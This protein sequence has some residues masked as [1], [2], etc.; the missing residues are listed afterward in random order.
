M[1]LL[2]LFAL[3]G[4]F[5]PFELSSRLFFGSILFVAFIV[6][7]AHLSFQP[8]LKLAP[9]IIFRLDDRFRKDLL[10]FV[11]FAAIGIVIFEHVQLS[12]ENLRFRESEGRSPSVSVLRAEGDGRRGMRCGASKPEYLFRHAI[13]AIRA[14]MKK[15]IEAVCRTEETRRLLYS[16]V[17]G[18]RRAI[19]YDL[20]GA[21]RFIGVAHFLALSGLHLGIIFLP[22]GKLLDRFVRNVVLR[23]AVVLIVLFVYIAVAGFKPSLI[24]AYFLV[25]IYMLKRIAGA[26]CTLFRCLLLSGLFIVILDAQVVFD[27]GFE[28]SFA[29]VFAIA[30]FGIPLIAALEQRIS[31]GTFFRKAVLYVTSSIA[32]TLSIQC[33]TLPIVLSLFKRSSLISPVA[34]LL[35]VLPLTL[36]LY[37][38]TA[39]SVLPLGLTGLPVGEV[40]RP[41]SYV[42][43]Y[44]PLKISTVP[45]PAILK[46][47][48]NIWIYSMAVALAFFALRQRAKRFVLLSIAVLFVVIS[49]VE[50]ALKNI[51]EP[52]AMWNYG[53]AQAACRRVD[54]EIIVERKGTVKGESAHAQASFAHGDCLLIR[55]KK[56]ILISTGSLNVH[57]TN[58]MMRFLWDKGAGS[59]DALIMKNDFIDH[60]GL[61]ELLSKV[62]VRSIFCSPYLLVSMRD[63]NLLD[64]Y[65]VEVVTLK[66]G[67]SIRLESLD[68]HVTGPVFP[69]DRK[70]LNKDESLLRLEGVLSR[71]RNTYLVKM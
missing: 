51:S 50:P 26:H 29:A 69:P 49:F 23:S 57:E 40:L 17:L 7:A 70:T 55:G 21:Y 52:F 11:A 16:L 59:I 31:S 20:Q 65:G 15:N 35:L 39:L 61:S 19:P 58:G 38:G 1:M 27:V 62:H 37:L 48:V 24:R 45:N 18:D 33:M 3:L 64:S 66:K 9:W 25:S 42:L 22:L 10:K 43:W 2:G 47:N 6:T 4:I 68:L 46:G 32:L 67:D 30:A 28:L 63:R 56:N 34:N 14:Y 44:L 54:T 60:R 13:G 8:E 12:R 5:S 41:L 53:K 36:F 71:G